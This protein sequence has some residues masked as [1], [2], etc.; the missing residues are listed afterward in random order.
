LRLSENGSIAAGALADITII[1]PNCEWTVEPDMFRSKSR[2][3]PFA[4]M[5]LK[6]LAAVTIVAGE[7]VFN[8]SREAAIQ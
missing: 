8:R 5:R 4:G 6:G 3:T 1:D 2:N 7:I